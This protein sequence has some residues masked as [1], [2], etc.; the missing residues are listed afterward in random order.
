MSIADEMR[1]GTASGRWAGKTRTGGAA[2]TLR[3]GGLGGKDQQRRPSES[4]IPP[5]GERSAAR[6]AASRKQQ[7]RADRKH[8]E[9]L[10]ALARV[11]RARATPAPPHPP[12][13][14]FGSAE[15]ARVLA[16]GRVRDGARRHPILD[17]PYV[18]VA[19][20]PKFQR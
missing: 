7:A 9:L 1:E 14:T 8:Q 16:L 4:S 2:S 17:T 5:T 18:S 11:E 3:A 13:P 20:P 10:D 12:L 15:R 19:N 6:P